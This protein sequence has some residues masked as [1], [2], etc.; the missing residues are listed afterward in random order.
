MKVF[1]YME[2]GNYEQV[3]YCR[4]QQSGLRA[5]IAI[6]NTALGP[7]LGGTR[8]W[9]Y[10]SEEDALIDVLRLAR[11]MT[12]KAAAAGLLLGGGK[13]VIIGDPRKDK[14]EELWRSFGRYVS[15]LGGRFVTAEDVGTTP[16]DMDI[17]RRETPF[18]MGCSMAS[19][20]CGNPSATTAL[21]V[22]RGMQ[23]AVKHVYGRTNLRGMTVAVQGLGSVGYALCYHLHEEGCRLVVAD[24]NHEAVG[25][26]VRD[27]GALPVDPE[28]VYSVECDLFAPC[29]LGAVVNDHT[30]PVFRCRVIAGSANN[31]LAEERHGEELH[32]RGIIYIPDYIINAGGLIKVA[33]EMVGFDQDKVQEK[34]DAIYQTT[35]Q[36][37]DA[38]WDSG[39]TTSQAADQMAEARVKAGTGQRGIYLGGEKVE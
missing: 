25:R 18:V 8:M 17:I 14:S 4:D 6:H 26:A 34:V 38:A 2:P 22:F 30:L 20:G 32:Q 27:F 24:L 37:L 28:K 36:V 31:V 39:L 21:G 33:Q 13:A 29:A 5:I 19:G 9:P 35:L 12:Y 11:G 10:T 3:V 23:A 1:D 15:S 16:E 7:A